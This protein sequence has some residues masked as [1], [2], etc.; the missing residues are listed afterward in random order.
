MRRIALLFILTALAMVVM[1]VSAAPAFACPDCGG[2]KG[3]NNAFNVMLEKGIN[4]NGFDTVSK[5]CG[6][7][8][9]PT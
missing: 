7:S 6:E 3:L 9:R 2:V 8:C 1:S 5:L 4:S